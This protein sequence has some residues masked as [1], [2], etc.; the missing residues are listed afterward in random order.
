[1]LKLSS[2]R[3]IA[4]KNINLRFIHIM[5]PKSIKSVS[6]YFIAVS[7]P[8]LIIICAEWGLRLAE[9][10]EEYPLFVESKQIPGYLQPNDKV[11]Q[12][13]FPAPSY[14]PAVS[15][16]TQYFLAQKPSDS[17]RIV[18]Q[19]GSTAAGFP[20]GRWGSLSGMLQQ[21][22]KRLYPEKNI[23][24]INTAMASVNSYTLIDFVDE[25]IA[26]QPDLVLV[27]AGHNEYLGI[28]GVGS[29]Y[30]SKGGRA[31][32]LLYLKLK[33]FKLYRLVE[34]LY[35]Q[36][37]VDIKN[38]SVDERTLMAKVAKEKA[39]V[40]GSELYHQGIEQLQ[41]NL[42]I[43]LADYQAAGIPVL[44]GNLASNEK[45]QIPFSAL[46]H[47]DTIS[48][49]ALTTLT[50]EKQLQR[51]EQLKQILTNGNA[52][53]A[54][55][56]FE[57]AN[58]YKLTGKQT[59]AL[60]HFKLAKDHDQLRF[61]APEQ[62]NQVI[63]ELEQPGVTLVDVQASLRADSIDGLIGNK[64]MLEHLHPTTRGYFLLA[65]AFA[66][67][68]VEQQ[69]V[70]SAVSAEAFVNTKEIAWKEIPVTKADKL[71][72]EYKVA[73]LTSDYP[74]TNQKITVPAPDPSTVEG[75]A[76]VKRLAGEDWLNLNRKLSPIYQREKDINEGAL[77][78]GLLADALPHEYN[79]TYIA[80]LIYKKANNIPLSLY[81][82]NRAVQMK[83]ESLPVRLSIAQNYF[84]L[85]DRNSSLVH[86]NF[87]KE[88]QPDHPDVDRFIKLVSSQ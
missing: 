83:P 20:Y 46:I 71:Y 44:L 73:K 60:N 45:D 79:L 67:T 40:F 23:E 80:G 59:L 49:N 38:A 51:I 55:N 78:S 10:G 12:R 22:F 8:F 47:K 27:Y 69:L 26:I 85:G 37:F 18:V 35:Y 2:F 24:I 5:S 50:N 16:D 48:L 65:N 62:F 42:S 3:N 84:L 28:M 7:I 66:K 58:L 14:A 33:E 25:I 30:A 36:W 68:I 15:P 56:H 82:L 6:F 32:T 87:V 70:G 72:G 74:F 52:D 43:L 13:F 88:Q 41:G 19:G 39:I 86:L 76:V 29:A 11:I 64:H 17:F 75:D 31:A 54:A 21:R 53:S 81:Y 34:S 63:A 57:L 1:M 77:I 61:R 4:I 9:Y